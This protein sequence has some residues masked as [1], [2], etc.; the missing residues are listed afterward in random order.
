[1]GYSL[2]FILVGIVFGFL[3]LK[4]KKNDK[5]MFDYT[6]SYEGLFAAFLMIA[7]RLITLFIGW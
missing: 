1:M 3:V 6:K 5:N 7:L 4:F 2:L